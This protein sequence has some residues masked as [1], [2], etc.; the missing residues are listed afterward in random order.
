M[1]RT[2][3]GTTLYLGSLNRSPDAAGYAWWQEQL[4]LGQPPSAVIEGFLAS[5]EYHDRFLP[6]AGEGAADALAL[7]ETP[8]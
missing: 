5:S 2:I 6:P 3:A 7:A 1:A 4:A 8:G